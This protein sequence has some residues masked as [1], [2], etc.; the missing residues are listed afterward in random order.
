MKAIEKDEEKDIENKIKEIYA[1]LLD[2]SFAHTGGCFAI[3]L[4]EDE[5]KISAVIKDGFE[6]SKKNRNSKNIDTQKI[7]VL[8]H[9]LAAKN[10]KKRTFF[11]IERPLRKEIL[12]L[13]GAVA[14]SVNGEFHCAGSIISVPGGSTGGT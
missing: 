10:N 6:L 8:E 7:N 13:D 14:V 3:I 1:T 12:S 4:T 11:E 2:V 5:A 9:L